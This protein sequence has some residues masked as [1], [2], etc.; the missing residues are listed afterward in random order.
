MS[1]L[2]CSDVNFC[3]GKIRRNAKV[4]KAQPAVAEA[5]NNEKTADRE[6]SA[7]KAIK[8]HSVTTVTS[9]LRAAA[10]IAERRLVRSVTARRRSKRTSRH[11][12]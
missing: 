9:L 7:G 8:R 3:C 4:A 2:C 6:R 11:L 10:F 5:E 1:A 12:A